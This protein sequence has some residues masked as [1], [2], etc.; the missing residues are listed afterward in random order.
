M[1]TTPCERGGI[2]LTGQE[3]IVQATQAGAKV[4]NGFKL[5]RE[6]RLF[7]DAGL[8]SQFPVAMPLQF[9]LLKCLTL[10][11][12]GSSESPGTPQSSA[13]RYSSSGVYAA[14]QT[15]S[16]ASLSSGKSPLPPR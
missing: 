6:Q 13:F 3:L 4:E 11:G 10:A 15:A 12:G 9:G 14:R 16:L 2:R 8:F 5:T 1:H 7:A